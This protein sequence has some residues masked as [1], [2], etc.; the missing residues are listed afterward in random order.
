MWPHCAARVVVSCR[1]IQ[2]A[3]AFVRGREQNGTQHEANHW[4]RCI[5]G[6]FGGSREGRHGSTTRRGGRGVTPRF[7]LA[8][9]QGTSSSRAL[10]IDQRG[11]VIARAQ[12]GLASRFP[13]PGWV[14]QSPLDIWRTQLAAAREAVRQAGVDQIRAVALTNQRETALL[15]RREGLEPV[16]SAIVWQCRRTSETAAELER[17]HG[18]QIRHRSGLTP[19]AYF[20]GPKISWLL[21]HAPGVRKLAETGD[22]VCGTVDSWLLANLTGAKIHAT[23]TTNASRTMLWNLRTGRWD[24]QLCDW[25]SVPSSLLADVRPSGHEFGLTDPS[26]FDSPLPILAVA[27]DQQASLYGHGITAPG[28]AKCTYGTGAFVLSHAGDSSLS[29][30]APDGLL[31]TAAADGGVAFEGGV[32]TA[33]SVVQWLRDDLGLAA[34]APE[35]S[36]L[37]ASVASSGGISFVPALAGLGSPHWDADARGAMLGITR[38]TTRAQ[39]ARAALESVAFRVREIVEAMESA[40]TVVSE[41]RADGGMT[42]SDVLMQIQANAL[43]RP[44]VRPSIQ[45]TTA[46]G[47]ARLAME[48]AGVRPDFEM[49]EHRFLPDGELESEFARWTRAR[50]AVQSMGRN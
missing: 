14:E 4:R 40:G 26:L 30:G 9:D 28:A 21:D 43:Q 5:A 35:I 50:Q 8:L 29:V 33:G 24:E 44:V 27:G 47:A 49:G 20:S 19:D 22:L 46:L 31:L 2:A 36:A 23:D 3:S 25:Q 11:R 18:D 16:G 39:I 15:W 1:E 6:R 10:V 37:A 42:S 12:H 34:S 7:V 38:A 48:T 17:A 45:E 32:F 13:E 41:L